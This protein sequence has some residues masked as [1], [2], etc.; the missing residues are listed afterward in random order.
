MQ[1]CRENCHENIN[2]DHKLKADSMV[3]TKCSNREPKAKYMHLSML[4]QWQNNNL[5]DSRVDLKA[6]EPNSIS[7]TPPF[8]RYS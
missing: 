1:T 4:T 3:I 8:F 7:H 5:A 2:G 6:G